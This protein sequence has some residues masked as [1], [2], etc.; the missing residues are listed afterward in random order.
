MKVAIIDDNLVFRKLTK[1]AFEHVAPGKVDV[2]LFENGKEAID[3]IKE[4]IEKELQ[5]PKL[6]LLDLNMPIMDGWDFLE[7]MLPIKNDRQLD[8]VIYIVSSSADEDDIKRAKN[9]SDVKGYIIKPIDINQITQFV[10]DF[11]E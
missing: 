6:I 4:H 1:I 9:I 5:V 10:S 8:L 11:M 7:E 3:H 2:L